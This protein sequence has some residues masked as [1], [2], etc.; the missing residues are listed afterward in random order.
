MILLH[1]TAANPRHPTKAS[2]DHDLDLD[3]FV[4]LPRGFTKNVAYD[5]SEK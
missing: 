3:K 4:T 1:I 5:V 2:N